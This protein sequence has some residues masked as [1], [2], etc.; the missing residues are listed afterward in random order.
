MGTD[1]QGQEGLFTLFGDDERGYDFITPEAL[2]GLQDVHLSTPGVLSLYVDITPQRLAEVPLQKRVE[3]LIGAE[4]DKLVEKAELA[5]FRSAARRIMEHV[6]FQF[7]PSGRGLAIF[8]A[9]EQGLW[10]VYH[11]PAPVDDCLE[12]GDHVYLRPLLM[13]MDEYERYGVVL[14]DREKARFFLYYLGEVAEYGIAEHDVTPPKTRDQGPGQLSHLRWLEEQYAHHFRNVAAVTTRLYEHERWERLVIGGTAD[15]A[16]HFREALP[17]ALQDILAGMFNAP[18]TVDFNRVRDEVFAIER[19]IEEQA[20]A[21]RVEAVITK[22]FKGSNAVLGL[23]DTMW[24]VQQGRVYILVVPEGFKHKGWRCEQCGGLVAD[25]TNQ[26]PP[27]CPYCEGPLVA[28]EDIIDVAMQQVLD[29]G[30]HLEVV[31]G[32]A[33][34]RIL[35]EGPIGA[36]LRY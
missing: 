12:W 6:Q 18:V 31:R 5:R 25:L 10:R 13:L 33:Q 9:P 3:A 17:K 30:G 22:T 16:E 4:E 11:L 32:P 34:S 28:E 35:E 2:Q 8:S 1:W 21:E 24:A 15:N 27:A 26:R 7:R 19:K 36:I 23:A 29:Q 20:E 14:L